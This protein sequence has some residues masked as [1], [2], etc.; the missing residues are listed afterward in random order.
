MHSTRGDVNP[1]E[2][3]VFAF[4]AAAADGGRNG[5]DVE[6]ARKKSPVSSVRRVFS[7]H[8]FEV[9]SVRLGILGRV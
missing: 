1:V 7:S 8:A 3:V 4:A 5:R 2:Q 6:L 9:S